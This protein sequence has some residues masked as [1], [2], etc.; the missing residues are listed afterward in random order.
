MRIVSVTPLQCSNGWATWTFVRIESDDS[1][2]GYGECSDWQMANALAGGIHDLGEVIIGKDPRRVQALTADMTFHL[3]QNVGGVGQKA[4]AGIEAALWD[5][6]GQAHATSIT[7]LLGGATRD[8]IRLYWSHCGSYRIRYP[9]LLGTPPINSW[10]DLSIL[11]KEVVSRGYTALKTNPFLP[12]DPQHFHFAQPTDGNLERN[13]L[14]VIVRQIE[15]LR[16]AVGQEVDICLDLNFRFR[17]S[18]VIS[19]AEALRP[20]E[21]LWIEYDSYD[22]DALSYIRQSITTPLCSGENLVTMS[23]YNRFFH[24]GSMDIAMVD[25]AW[26]GISQSIRIAE[27]A[28]THEIQVAPHNYYSHISTFMCAH[29][30]AVVT[31]LRIMETDVDSAPWRDELVTVTPT[32]KDGWLYPPN[33][34]G[35]GTTLDEDALAAH[36]PRST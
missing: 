30:A 27:L 8:R 21:L 13:D 19:I 6:K 35:L 17:P 36:P 4:L 3:R 33:E 31:N 29:M 24:S 11:G 14:R 7:D 12:G 28:S 18:A 20:Y 2:V 9:K 22:R 16:E 1:H 26:N 23:D 25:V 32:I 15:T 34:P 5:L 10:S